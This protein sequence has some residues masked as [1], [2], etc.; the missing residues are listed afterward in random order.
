[1][2]VLFCFTLTA[3]GEKVSIDFPFELSYVENVEMFHFFNPAEAEKKV[4]TESEDIEDIYQ[5]FESISLKDK[6]TEPTA[7]GSVTSF[8]FNLSD[9]TFYEI[10]YSEVAVKSGR[11]ITTDMEQDFFTSANIAANWETY[12]YEV[13]AVSEDEL[14]RLSKEEDSNQ[15]SDTLQRNKI[16]MIMVDGR[17]YYDTG[18][19]STIEGRCGVM[20]GKITSNV[21][22]SEIPTEDN[23]SN[24]GTGFEY[25][26]GDDDT[27][28]IFMNEKWIV[29]EH[30]E[31]TEN[32]VRFGGHMVDADKLSKET[33]EW[34]AWYNSLPEEDQL[35]VNYIPPDLYDEF[36]FAETEDAESL[37]TE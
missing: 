2:T 22:G 7:G 28:E 9:G 34:L 37:I 26:Y 33:L 31:D 14:P 18:K 21:E 10:V 1:M 29:F 5:I 17:L 8:R 15:D 12:D 6:A 13:M 11:I 24:F 32:Q 23:Q 27:I 4:I 3:C 25:Q 20:D 30:R 16:P 35:A 19:E 36:G